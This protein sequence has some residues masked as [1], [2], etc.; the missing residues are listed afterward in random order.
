MTEVKSPISEELVQ[1]EMT[2]QAMSGEAMNWFRSQ[3]SGY[4]KLMAYYNCAM[5]EITTKL[6]VLNEEFSL[7]HDHNPI[8][9]IKSRLKSF[10]SIQEKLARRG[11]PL[12][13]V[14]IEE[15]LTDVAGVR[16]VCAF[17]EDVQMLADA[18]LKQDDLVLVQRKD[19]IQNPKPN[20]YRSLHLIVEVPIY[21]A[22]EKRRMKVEIQLRT[23]AMDFWASLEHQ[24]KYKKDVDVTETDWL[25]RELRECADISAQLDQRMDAIRRKLN[26]TK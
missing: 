25:S 20:G 12:S 10:Y 4:R 8:A 6:N 17:P 24:I 19:Y 9:S 5:M 26:K 13:T 15:N 14:S 11:L 1:N 3:T 22:H 16:V 23:I 7:Q 21:L 18:L 2:Y